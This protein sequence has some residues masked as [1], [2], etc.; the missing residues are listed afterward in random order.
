MADFFLK[1]SKPALLAL[2]LLAMALV[3][4]G[5]YFA[6][7]QLLEFSV[8]FLLPICFFTWFFSRRAGLLASLATGVLIAG[9]N[10]SSPTYL[11][12]GR[13]AYW[14]AL[15][16]TVFFILITL[17]IADMKNLHVRER[18]LAR[19]DSLTSAATRL[20][21]Y[22]FADDE[23]NRARR[24]SE[25]ITLA[26]LDLDCFKEINDRNGHATGD[27]VL[28]AVARGIQSHIRRT[29]MVARLG[30]D[31][32]AL[33]LPNTRKDAATML[34]AKVLDAL[35]N[36]MQRRGWPVTFSVG[37]LTFISPPESVESMVHRADELMYSV[38]R[39]G[40]NRMRLEE[41]SDSRADTRA[42]LAAS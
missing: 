3:G 27:S 33:L 7:S 22:E 26:Y 39:T 12:H 13:I 15:V 41:T 38:K 28:V 14:N 4:L 35:T 40:K 2:G 21:F 25:P 29:D 34:L 18:D 5:D 24:T 6:T 31:E 32:F 1:R 36:T 10:I 23:I 17:I 11:L 8:F 19:V 20:A 30:G 16:W 37:A 42:A 9:V